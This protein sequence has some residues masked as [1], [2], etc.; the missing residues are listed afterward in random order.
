[1]YH[2][3]YMQTY[4]RLKLFRRMSQVLGEAYG[5]WNIWKWHVWKKSATDH[6]TVCTWEY[7][8]NKLIAVLLYSYFSC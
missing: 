2:S 8:E 6:Y 4:P 3:W 1:M 5:K 7:K